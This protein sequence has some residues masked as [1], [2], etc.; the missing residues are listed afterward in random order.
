MYMCYL[1]TQMKFPCFQQCKPFAGPI[2]NSGRTSVNDVMVQCLLKS[3]PAFLSGTS[4]TV[5]S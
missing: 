4:G 2:E 5:P 3:N 1:G